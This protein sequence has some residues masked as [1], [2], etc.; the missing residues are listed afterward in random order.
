[1][2]LSEG[3]KEQDQGEKAFVEWALT[4]NRFADYQDTVT[5]DRANEKLAGFDCVLHLDKSARAT[6]TSSVAWNIIGNS[7]PS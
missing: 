4:S 3:S 2:H 5:G 6:S 7:R 1:M